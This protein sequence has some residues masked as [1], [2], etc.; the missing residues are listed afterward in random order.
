MH[1]PSLRDLPSPPSGKTGWPWTEESS[2]LL[3]HRPE[4]QSWP[5]I[6]VVTPSF[7]QGH[8]IEET[9]RSILLQGYPDLEYFVLDGGSTDDTVS[10]I[11][12]YSRW[13]TH[14]SSEPDG[15]QS[16]AIN[17]GLRMGSGFYATWINSDD[18]LCKDAI[19][20]LASREPL[21]GDVVY[22]GDCVNIDETGKMLFSQRGRVHTL[23]DLLRVPSVW[24]HGGYITQPEVLFPLE[25]AVRV[26][27]LNE[28][29]HWTMDY[30]LWGQFFLAGAKIHYTGIPFG[31]FR[32]HGAQKTQ[33]RLKQ[34]ESML[35]TAL[36]LV[37]IATDLSVETKEQ[38]RAELQA[39]RDAYPDELWRDSGR[40][41][42]IGLPR[43]VVDALRS[44]K[45]AAQKTKKRFHST[46]TE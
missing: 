11:K 25:L 4:V 5:R 3:E 18:M 8:F 24:R 26:G 10:V 21:N 27:G 39:Y 46:I 32:L 6:T 22:I 30:E 40:L 1:C 31:Q 44:F 13:I 35:D 28:Q 43:S 17:T 16:A 23:E 36:N 29:N 7:N 14:W 45:D 37:N 15:G 33:Q 12:K 9:I 38:L 19:V 2:A 41:A 20:N 34:T 42:R